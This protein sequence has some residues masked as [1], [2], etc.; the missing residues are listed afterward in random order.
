MFFFLRDLQ[1]FYDMNLNTTALFLRMLTCDCRHLLSSKHECCRCCEPGS[2]S[3]WNFFLNPELFVPDPAKMRRKKPINDPKFFV[4][5]ALTVQQFWWIV[6]YK[7][8]QI[9]WFFFLIDFKV[10]VRRYCTYF[11]KFQNMFKIIGVGS[12]FGTQKNR[13]RIP[14][15]LSF[16]I[17]YTGCRYLI[18]CCCRPA[19]RRCQP[20]RGLTTWPDLWTKLFLSHSTTGTVRYYLTPWRKNC[21]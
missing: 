11:Y 6:S 2:G 13:G 21:C 20:T 1:F 8:I 15:I 16:R 10:P 12:G 3:I 5:V 9:G 19:R 17:H 4:I 7:V 14:N 18:L